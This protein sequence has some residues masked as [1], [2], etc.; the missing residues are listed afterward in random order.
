LDADVEQLAGYLAEI[1]EVFTGEPPDSM[2]GRAVDVEFL[3][4]RSPRP[5]VIVQARPYTVTWPRGRRYQDTR[6]K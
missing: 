3:L 1:H 2:T 6:G 5:I 4:A